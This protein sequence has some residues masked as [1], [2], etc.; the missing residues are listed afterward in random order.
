VEDRSREAIHNLERIGADVLMVAGGDGS[1]SIA[2]QFASL[3]VNVIGIPKTI[4]N[5][6]MATDVSFG[7]QTA[8]ETATDALNKLHTTAESHHRVMVCEVMG[9]DSGWIA[10]M[11]G[12]AGG[13]NVILIPEIPFTYENVVDSLVNR[14]ER[15]K[16]FSIIV[17]AEGARLPE[18]EAVTRLTPSGHT[19]FGGI[20]EIIAREV[21][22][23]T[24][25][26]TRVTVLGHLQ[27]GGP[28]CAFDRLLA[29][30]LGVKAVTM[31]V[32]G[33]FSSMACLRGWEISSAP[34]EEAVA[35][36]K[37]VRP[38]TSIVRFARS[39]GISFGDRAVV[40]YS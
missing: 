22:N 14:K 1:L 9:R 11:S 3:G 13:G 29:T 27:R 12:I 4:D 30:S 40:P 15:D 10:L 21:E 24:G 18:G 33:E 16:S 8:V 23:R 28:P 25:I 37:F 34:L 26:E 7:F 31:A 32:E 38:E 19:V 36:K 5:D 35:R 2:L 39:I 20:S 17:V 6:L